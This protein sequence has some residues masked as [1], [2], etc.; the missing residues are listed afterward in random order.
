VRVLLTT[1]QMMAMTGLGRTA[2]QDRVRSG[3]IPAFLEGRKWVVRSEDFEIWLQTCAWAAAVHEKWLTDCGGEHSEAA[4][5]RGSR[6]AGCLKAHAEVC[7]RKKRNRVARRDHAQFEHGEHGYSNWGCRCEVCMT[8]WSAKMRRD[9][10]GRQERTLP[11]AHSRGRPWSRSD[12]RFLEE[13]R[14]TMRA[15]DMALALG[16]TYA[17]VTNALHRLD[18]GALAP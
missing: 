9:N 8:A 17:A 5:M 3:E 4:Y 13:N 15:E 10:H 14:H 1:A 18:V 2:I 16:R 7:A 6:D 12:L 11:R